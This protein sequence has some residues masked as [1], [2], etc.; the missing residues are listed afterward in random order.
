MQMA[1]RASVELHTLI[2]FRGKVVVTEAR[3]IRVRENGLILFVPKFGI[4]AP[5]YF[6]DGA[7][8]DT[9]GE[10]Q[11]DE[12][13]MAVASRRAQ[14]VPARIHALRAWNGLIRHSSSR[15]VPITFAGTVSSSTESSTAARCALTWRG[16]AP[17][18]ERS[19]CA[20]PPT[21]EQTCAAATS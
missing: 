2:F 9:I 17:H 4:E 18:R 5:V 12:Q 15:R 16:T 3:V 13:D 6:A 7:K 21:T 10:W 14:R 11:L 19:W 20:S 1:G 8:T